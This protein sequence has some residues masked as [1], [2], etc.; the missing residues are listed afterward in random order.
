MSVHS[1]AIIA[2]CLLVATVCGWA[3]PQ[4]WR[5]PSV[6]V[7]GAAMLALISPAALLFIALGTAASIAVA[8][9]RH[10]RPLTPI[11]VVAMAIA[12]GGFLLFNVRTDALSVNHWAIPFAMAY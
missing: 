6:T 10:Q 8:R 1:I 5:M 7:C 2:A 4:R 3:L 9:S 12:Y 11:F